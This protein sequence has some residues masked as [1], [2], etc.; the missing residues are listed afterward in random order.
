[1]GFAARLGMG[2]AR[3]DARPAA[4]AIWHHPQRC[5]QRLRERSAAC[6][7]ICAVWYYTGPAADAQ[8]EHLQHSD[9]R[10]LEGPTAE[11]ALAWFGGVQD[12]QRTPKLITY[13]V[14]NS[15]CEK[16]RHP[17]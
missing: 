3:Y 2:I 12:Q 9:Q 16:C 7:S 4:D 13:R 11:R 5:H 17:V 15:S 6:K 8:Q 1:M 10:V 14:M